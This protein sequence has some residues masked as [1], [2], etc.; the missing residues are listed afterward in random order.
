[1]LQLGGHQ[2]EHI[3]TTTE[4][5]AAGGIVN[6]CLLQISNRYLVLGPPSRTCVL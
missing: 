3:L 1:V 4:Q 2:T 6:A 5:T